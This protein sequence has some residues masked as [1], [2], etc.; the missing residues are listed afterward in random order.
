MIGWWSL[1]DGGGWR[2]K[3]GMRDIKEPWVELRRDIPLM[4]NGEG[5]YQRIEGFFWGW[6]G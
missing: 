4:G 5:W 2:E 1:C 3:G 6:R